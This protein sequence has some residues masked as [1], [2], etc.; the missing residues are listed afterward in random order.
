[1]EPAWVSKANVTRFVLS[2]SSQGKIFERKAKYQANESLKGF[3]ARAVIYQGNERGSE[4]QGRTRLKSC[5][6]QRILDINISSAKNMSTWGGAQLFVQ[7]GTLSQPGKP[8]ESTVPEATRQ[9]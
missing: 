5:F 2:M 3:K 1:M 8:G 4:C 9:N 6:P 7:S